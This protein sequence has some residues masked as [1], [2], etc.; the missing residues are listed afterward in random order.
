MYRRIAL[1]PLWSK[2]P[3]NA[4]EARYRADRITAVLFVFAT[5][6]VSGVMSIGEIPGGKYLT[7]LLETIKARCPAVA[8]PGCGEIQ[9]VMHTF[10]TT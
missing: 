9:K 8:D 3:R 10:P 7:A 2:T 1:C 5:S 6:P 4:A